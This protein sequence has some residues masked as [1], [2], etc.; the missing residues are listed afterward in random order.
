MNEKNKNNKNQINVKNLFSNDN[1]NFIKIEEEKYKQ[2]NLL[3]ILG[4]Q[5]NVKVSPSEFKIK[6]DFMSRTDIVEINMI[7]NDLSFKMGIINKELDSI[8]QKYGYKIYNY[9]EKNIKLKTQIEEYLNTMHQKKLIKNEI[10]KK[11][12]DNSAKLIMKGLRQKKL[13]KILN[14]LYELKNI[15]NDV[16]YLDNILIS[17]DYFEIKD[18]SNK[19][20][21]LK[22]RMKEYREKFKIKNRLKLF[23]NVEN[24]IKSYES[25]GEEK[26]FTQFTLNLE[27][28]L[29]ICLIYKKEDYENLK[30]SGNYDINNIQKWNLEKQKETKNNFFFMNED[31]ELIENQTNKFIKYLLIYNNTNINLITNLL[32]SILDMYETIIK[33]GMDM[34]IITSK[35]KEILRKIILNNFDLIEKESNNKL[36]II[37]II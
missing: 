30:K 29:N 20:N 6:K 21:N 12:I 31:F 25:K 28:I 15:K 18:I 16:I 13:K 2:S 9:T 34:N 8:L 10:N 1:Y 26:M 27:K 23:K 33:D 37:Y 35:Y 7:Q 5:D 32:L 22:N 17:D 3:D 11:Y 36:V 4:V 24:R 19:I 14:Y